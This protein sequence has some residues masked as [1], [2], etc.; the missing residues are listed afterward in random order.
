MGPIV[1]LKKGPMCCRETS[2]NPRRTQLSLPVL[3]EVDLEGI[4]KGFG[5]CHGKILPIYPNNFLEGLRTIR[6]IVSRNFIT[7]SRFVNEAFCM[8]LKLDREV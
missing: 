1:S 4:W 6:N 2:L 5:V 7:G 8:L 3:F